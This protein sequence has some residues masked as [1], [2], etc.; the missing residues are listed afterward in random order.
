MHNE[1]RARDDEVGEQFRAVI[2]RHGPG[3]AVEVDR[4]AINLGILKCAARGQL[5]KA[6]L[7]QGAHSRDMQGHNLYRRVPLGEGVELLMQV[8]EAVDRGGDGFR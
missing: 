5:R 3:T 1:C 2:D 7:Q 8:V 6:G 4:V